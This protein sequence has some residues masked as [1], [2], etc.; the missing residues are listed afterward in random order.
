MRVISFDETKNFMSHL[1]I[2]DTF[3]PFLL[4]EA[5]ITTYKTI[6]LDGHI[7]NSYFT[8]EELEERHALGERSD[9]LTWKEARSF[10]YDQIKGKKLPLKLQIILSAPPEW[11]PRFL[12][13][14]ELDFSPEQV[15]GLYFN[16]RFEDN[17]LT[18]STASS[19]SI[20][21][22][23]QSLEESWCTYITDY[24]KKCI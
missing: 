11:I 12:T 13:V 14:K 21:T 1:F 4:Q 2:K 6:F 20:F 16:I 7:H 10:C 22:L 24:L 9:F 5:T 23:D 8:K 19:L 17:K 18:L 15:K 3:H